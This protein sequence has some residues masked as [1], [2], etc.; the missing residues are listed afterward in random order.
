MDVRRHRLHR[1]DPARRQRH[2]LL[3][4]KETLHNIVRHASARHVRI[5]LSTTPATFTLEV[6]DDGCGM[7]PAAIPEGQGFASLRHRAQLLGGDNQIRTTPGQ[8]TTVTFTGRLA[9]T[10]AVPRHV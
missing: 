6:T 10:S 4:L 7:D 2:L 5:R 9:P 1:R 3:A 8:G